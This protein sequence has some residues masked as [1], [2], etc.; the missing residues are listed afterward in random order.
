[1]GGRVI[2]MLRRL[3]V[4]VLLS[5]MCCSAAS[6]RADA[7]DGDSYPGQQSAATDPLVMESVAIGEAFWLA[8]GVQPCPTPQV[9]IADSL[10]GEGGDATGRAL[11]WGC[12]IWLQALMAA[13]ASD[14]YPWFRAY[15]C[16]AVTHELGHTAGLGHSIGGVMDGT[17]HITIPWDCWHWARRTTAA[18]RH[19][20]HERARLRSRAR[21][22]RRHRAHQSSA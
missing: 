22:A 4:A 20:D 2:G 8:R 18:A 9:Y 16:A 6:A 3:T 15:L 10:P 7:G 17:G 13:T 5:A 14:D 19:Q 1:M 11:L 21:R 12:T